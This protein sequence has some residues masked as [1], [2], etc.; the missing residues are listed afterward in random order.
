M[1]CHSSEKKKVMQRHKDTYCPCEKSYYISAEE[2][3]FEPRRTETLNG[4]FLNEPSTHSVHAAGPLAL[5]YV[6]W[7]T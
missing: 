7:V 6:N 2:H 3:L 4:R 1:N 5:A